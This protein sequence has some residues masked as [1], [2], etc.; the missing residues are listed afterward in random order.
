MLERRNQSGGL[1]VVADDRIVGP[2]TKQELRKVLREHLVVELCLLGAERRA[3]AG[4]IVQ[5]VVEAL[6]YLEEGLR[7]FEYEPADVDAKPPCVAKER[8]NDLSNA[9]TLGG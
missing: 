1:R 6:G 8:A 2:K 9:A 5:R 7:P 3:V 4:V